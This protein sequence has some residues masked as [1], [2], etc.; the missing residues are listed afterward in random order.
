MNASLHYVRPVMLLDA[1]HFKSSCKGTMHLATVKTGLNEI[2]TVA[3][4]I[5]RANEGY[6][7]WH[8]FLLHLKNVCL[9]L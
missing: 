3:I 7:G 1:T 2:Y 6:D 4:A 8:T 5:A 9:V